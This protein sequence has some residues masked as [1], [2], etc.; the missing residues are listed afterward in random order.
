MVAEKKEVK[1]K[2]EEEEKD[3]FSG[4]EFLDAG[5]SCAQETR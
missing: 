2:C 4:G 5:K 1:N 3:F